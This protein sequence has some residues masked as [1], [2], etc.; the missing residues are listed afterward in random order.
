MYA[1]MLLAMTTVVAEPPPTEAGDVQGVFID[2]PN[3][4]N[5]RLIPDG[6]GS[7]CYGAGTTASFKP[8]TLD[9]TEV[10]KEL[11]KTAIKNAPKG[12]AFKVII[13][14]KGI[15]PVYVFTNDAKFILELFEKA[16]AKEV[17][18]G[19]TVEFEQAWKQH[20]P[21]MERGK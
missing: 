4:W 15:D 8:R 1:I 13:R 20:P 14:E 10:V 5:L 18:D 3:F 12:Y 17:S 11:R 19:R 2:T 7:L 6:S 9:F 21:S 16:A